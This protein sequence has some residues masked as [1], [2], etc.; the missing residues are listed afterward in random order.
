MTE[1]KPII[2]ITMG[3]PAGIGPEILVSALGGRDLYAGARPL[4]IGDTGILEAAQAIAG[5]D[6]TFNPIADPGSA[7]FRF[8]T[9][10]V[11]DRSNLGLGKPCWG[12]PTRQTGQAMIDYITH[13]ID[14]AL[15]QKVDA[16]VTGPINKAA[17][18]LAES[19]FHGH[20]ELLA[21]RTK[22]GQF[23]MM[24]AGPKLRIVLVTIHIP[25]KDVPE[26]VT[27][28]KVLDT[29]IITDTALKE[30]FG[31]ERPKI[32]VAGLNPHA[33]EEGLF[34]NEE[35]TRI[36]PAIK[37]AKESGR[38]VSGPFPPDTVYQRAAAGHFDA[39]VSMYHDQGLIPFKMIHF[40][41][42]V[43]TTVGLP[44]IRTSVDH[45]TAYDIAGRG[46]AD[47]SSLIAA[48]EMATLQASF[49]RNP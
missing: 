20:T 3:D 28:E 25:L 45:G 33:G 39:V 10:D 18:K 21:H 47:P 29:I 15:W 22:A 38:D 43:N 13:G 35:D 24:M 2:G 41:D 5:T 36:L 40:A 49:R 19:E 27:P 32:A 4:V 30:R 23:A 14:L 11:I 8:G 7:R 1:Q 37:R 17:M 9:V 42:G 6:L 31:I 48:I 16:L 46:E 44:I 34:G 12:A 26:A